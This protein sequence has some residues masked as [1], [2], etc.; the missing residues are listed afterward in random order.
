MAKG[1]E[2][3]LQTLED[4]IQVVTVIN[5][6]TGNAQLYLALYSTDPGGDN[7]GT[8]VNYAGYERQEVDFDNPPAMNGAVAEILNTNAIEFETVTMESGVV[9]F[10]AIFTALTGGTLLYYGPLGAS[11]PL[12]VGVKPT[13]PVGGLTVYEN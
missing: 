5:T 10:A 2:A 12:N 6:P 11:Y 1:N 7:S 3:K 8:E 4:N 13:V 9:A